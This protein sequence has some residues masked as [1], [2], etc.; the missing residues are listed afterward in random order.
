MSRGATARL[1]VA[2]DP[3][4]WARE[5]LAEWARLIA[6]ALDPRGGARPAG[7]VRLLAPQLLHLT[8]CFLGNRPVGEIASLSSAL[9]ALSERDLELSIG[10]PL[11]LPPRRPRAVAVEVHG[12]GEELSLLHRRLVESLAA[13]GGW[14]PERRRFRPHI[15]VARLRGRDA[16]RSGRDP[17]T[18][19]RDPERELLP[20]TPR[21]SFTAESLCLYRS[22]LTP[23][24]ASY[25]V[26]AEW[27]RGAV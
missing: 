10:G 12:H 20:A 11:L 16:G 13:A 4:L 22:R 7:A 17:E 25:E 26:L 6:P 1:F 24:G 27:G 14:E 23:T 21:L 18:R 19:G 15:T 8:L 9:G 3:P 5:E 2:L